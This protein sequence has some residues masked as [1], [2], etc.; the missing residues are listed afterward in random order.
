MWGTGA[1]YVTTP[2]ADSV[3]R[4]RRGAHT[5]RERSDHGAARHGSL[6]RVST[7]PGRE[8]ARVDTA[9]ALAAGQRLELEQQLQV[10][11][12]RSGPSTQPTC[13]RFGRRCSTERQPVDVVTTPFGIRTI[14][15][16]KDRGFLLNGRR[17]KLSGVNLHHD[18]GALG[19]AV[20]ERVWERRLAL[21]K[22]MGV[23][24][25][26]HLAQ[27]AGA[28]VPR[29]VRSPGISRHGRGVRRV[30]VRQGP[31]GLSQVLR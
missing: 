18:A 12:P 24:R 1:T 3:A 2:R 21:L 22:A 5:A 26:P 6:R 19:A 28:R 17:V 20:P 7:A 8:V 9:F 29:P 16:D 14:A 25:H 11:T 4:R 15:F 23:E 10:A 13:T 27:P 30:D 31:R